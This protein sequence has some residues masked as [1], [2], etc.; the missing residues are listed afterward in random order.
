[1]A[2]KLR[3][4]RLILFENVIN[5]GQQHSGNGNDRLVVAAPF[6][7]V[8]IAASDF[9]MSFCLDSTERALYQ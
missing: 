5:G 8:Q 3:V 7:E 6:L 4:V 1:M 2:V 9:W